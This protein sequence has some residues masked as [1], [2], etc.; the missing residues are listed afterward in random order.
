MECKR[1]DVVGFEPRESGLCV[2]CEQLGA[3]ERSAAYWW[4]EWHRATGKPRPKATDDA[5]EAACGEIEAARLRLER[6]ESEIE[7]KDRVL[8]VEVSAKLA[9]LE[10]LDSARK[11]LEIARAV[12]SDYRRLLE[13]READEAAA[14]GEL[15]INIEDAQPGTVAAKLLAANRILLRNL[16]GKDQTIADVRAAVGAGFDTPLI[17]AVRDLIK[18]SHKFRDDR[19]R[20]RLE[21]T[22]ARQNASR[23]AQ[24]WARDSASRDEAIDVVIAELGKIFF[25]APECWGDKIAEIKAALEAAKTEPAHEAEIKDVAERLEEAPDDG[26]ETTIGRMVRTSKF[27]E[28]VAVGLEAPPAPECPAMDRVIGYLKSRTET[29]AALFAQGLEAVERLIADSE[30]VAG[31][32]KNGDLAP[33]SELRTGGEF[34]EWL[35]VFDAALAE[36]RRPANEERSGLEPEGGKP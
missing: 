12:A 6:I 2:A 26:T 30:G 7:R 35:I 17:E 32:H 5:T 19:N 23:Y 18:L 16:D 29:S 3:V 9:A 25:V 15:A 33:W 14:A 22:A 11:D 27:L 34:C 21:R 10:E 4:I 13:E 28:G 36:L 8:A 20:L 1:C 24:G 31:L